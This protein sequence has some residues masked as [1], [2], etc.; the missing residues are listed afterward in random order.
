MFYTININNDI[1]MM[2]W[3][4]DNNINQNEVTWDK[5]AYSFDSTR[6]K[7]W[8]QCIDFIDTLPEDNIIADVGCGNGRHLFHCAK[9]C[10]KA[11]GID[12]SKELIRIV[13]TKIKVM[14]LDNIDLI[15][16][17]A[18]NLPI[19]DNVFNA[20]LYIASLHNIKGNNNRINSLKE[21]YRILKNDGKALVSV[22]SRWQDNFRK[23][24][25]KRWFTQFKQ[26]KFGDIDIYW[27]K[28]GLYIPRFYHLY[29]K[30]EFIK[31]LKKANFEIIEFKEEKLRSNRHPDNFF[32]VTKKS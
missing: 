19:K 7:P 11:I 27:K 22:W 8:K 3:M 2:V 26:N 28:H 6:R 29:S 15:H 16:T 1:L 9:R 12:I 14:N 4:I 10:K 31:D 20:V 5:I 18:I 13:Q 32:A 21:I 24:F 23:E 30:R 25:F 17:D